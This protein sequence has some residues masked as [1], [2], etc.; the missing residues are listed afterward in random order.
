MLRKVVLPVYYS[1]IRH[2]TRIPGVPGTQIPGVASESHI[3][4]DSLGFRGADPPPDF[5]D[6][7]TIISVGGSTTRSAAQS[8]DR[9]W[10]ALLGDAVA[11][12]THHHDMMGEIY[13]IR[14]NVGHLHEDRY[15][16]TCVIRLDLVK[17][18][19]IIER[20]ARSALA[21]IIGD[22]SLWLHFANTKG[23]A[24]FWALPPGD[25]QR[26]WGPPIDPL[27]VVADFDPRFIHDGHLGA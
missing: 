23:R 15:L 24:A 25:R 2:N 22:A 10:T 17:K 8:D 5:A 20:I 13:D 26:I 3:H 6:R 4:Q 9:T 21:R 12:C 18:E 19:A 16:E 14:S 1:E 11:D 7:L 27:A